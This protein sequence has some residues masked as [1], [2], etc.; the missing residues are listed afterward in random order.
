MRSIRLSNSCFAEIDGK[1]GVMMR[2]SYGKKA[3]GPLP[4]N[5]PSYDGAGDDFCINFLLCSNVWN[6]YGISELCPG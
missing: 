5:V 3:A 1:Q 2:K 6:C 4:D